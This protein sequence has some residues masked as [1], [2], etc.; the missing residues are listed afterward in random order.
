[1]GVVDLV[2]AAVASQ[3]GSPVAMPIPDTSD[4]FEARPFGLDGDAGQRRFRR[5]LEIDVATGRFD[6]LA[7]FA[8]VVRFVP[9]GTPVGP[10]RKR[11]DQ[12]YR[13]KQA[14]LVL[15]VNALTSVGRG[16]ERAAAAGGLADPEAPG[17]AL[18][19]LSPPEPAWVVYEGVTTD[20][21]V[22]HWTVFDG[23][24]I[25]F[26]SD[27]QEPMP[28]PQPPQ[29]PPPPSFSALP[30]AGLPETEFARWEQELQRLAD[31]LVRHPELGALIVGHTDTTGHESDNQKLSE[32]R[33][34]M[35]RRRLQE[36]G[37]ENPMHPTGHGE[38]DLFQKEFNDPARR[39]LN[40]RVEITVAPL[41]A[42]ESDEL[43]E[44]ARGYAVVAT[45][46]KIG[47]FTGLLS[48]TVLDQAGYLLD[49]LEVVRRFDTPG[50]LADHP[51]ARTRDALAPAI[52][53][54]WVH[55]LTPASGDG[56][57]DPEDQPFFAFQTVDSA[58]SDALAAVL[59][60]SQLDG[61]KAGDVVW[62]CDNL[63]TS[64][65]LD[66]AHAITL[67]GKGP[68]DTSVSPPQ[69]ALATLTPRD[70]DK[71]IFK[72][73]APGLPE[74][75]VRILGLR[76]LNGTAREDGGAIRL[77]GVEDVHLAGCT[78]GHNVVQPL[79]GVAPD[80]PAAAESRPNGGALALSQC[81]RV[82]IEDCVFLVNEAQNGGAVYGDTCRDVV[83]RSRPL[84]AAT[85][86]AFGALLEVG[87]SVDPASAALQLTAYRSRFTDN[88][89]HGSGGAIMLRHS[90][91]RIARCLFKGNGITSGPYGAAALTR[92]GG[93]LAVLLEAPADA[94]ALR[95]AIL[96]GANTAAERDH[97]LV[98]CA[99]VA[100]AASE[101]G[102][103]VAVLG[104]DTVTVLGI[105]TLLA[106]LLRAPAAWPGGGACL[107]AGNVVH[108]NGHASPEETIP[109]PHRTE[110]GGA[111]FVAS[112]AV[113]IRHTRI[114]ANTAGCGGG[115]A[116]V[117]TA[118][119]DVRESVMD[120]NR[121]L[122][123]GPVGVGDFGKRGGGG[124]YAQ[125]FAPSEDP[126]VPLART[127]LRL[128][129]NALA[130]HT[131]V[132]D[133]GAVLAT[134]GARVE[135]GVIG[136]PAAVANAFVGNT[137]HGNGG[138][139]AI[140]N[141]SLEVGSGER[142]EN[143]RAL[144]GDGGGIFVGGITMYRSHPT[145]ETLFKDIFDGGR[146]VPL[147]SDPGARLRL[148][149]E[150]GSPV[151]FLGNRANVGNAGGVDV[152]GQGGAVFV[153]QQPPLR[154]I[155]QPGALVPVVD[156]TVGLVR[157]VS[158]RGVESLGDGGQEEREGL[159]GS[160]IA[161]Q[162]LDHDWIG[163]F[164]GQPASVQA[165]R[166][167][168]IGQAPSGQY[169]L[170]PYALEGIDIELD[171]GA[172]LL[173]IDSDAVAAQALSARQAQGDPEGTTWAS[174]LETSGERPLQV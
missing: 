171:Q 127:Q 39:A 151:R 131:C 75:G 4:L 68:L 62:L 19:P 49:P 169:L 116:C 104:V 41:V 2:Y 122:G 52:A 132:G 161:L 14:G 73:S 160:A 164:D 102:G 63:S 128:I 80:S 23:I 28:L 168:W 95:T 107:L 90:S 91:F 94:A 40:R 98:R 145:S 74:V 117:A 7:M 110:F 120:R 32:R 50:L 166:D 143:N 155:Q 35:F 140:Q 81:Q 79:S 101:A 106:D 54:G 93:A 148:E 60:G 64:T 162:G 125:G 173:R 146:G 3:V 1:M 31:E 105:D 86:A 139:I 163:E 33:A 51:L 123:S 34:Q 167:A 78:F 65:T 99:F 17:F 26:P 100:N 88:R 153:A 111:V 42:G 6:V 109:P 29:L 48:V 119:A 58:G 83:I 129:G 144:F 84:D 174:Q 15:Q 141:A 24:P 134:R 135:C 158:L 13:T 97:A 56:V 147:W 82:L 20:R 114:S 69:R 152:G 53:S 133:G 170:G 130:E 77:S 16:L 25:N 172:G 72:V 113:V 71:P 89:A 96:G 138:A 5:K 159:V 12:P 126:R 124:L 118:L 47:E 121:V 22:R 44:V 149:A 137:A 59:G 61:V 157:E 37:V 70:A 18:S 108:D 30:T 165:S 67:L 10:P 87:P 115:I 27:S 46:G 55:C 103:A 43:T 76:F 136:Q 8:G 38:T 112:A 45:G 156:R 150:A 85:E 21:P 11:D 57:T 9:V 154:T 66:L 92:R 142:F 36:L